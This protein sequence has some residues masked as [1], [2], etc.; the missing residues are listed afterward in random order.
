MIISDT[1]SWKILAT[2]FSLKDGL[3]EFAARGSEILPPNFL[4]WL[5]DGFNHDS[6]LVVERK[7]TLE[8]NRIWV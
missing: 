5:K 3:Y 6:L 1:Y 8:S 2:I 4:P 7:L